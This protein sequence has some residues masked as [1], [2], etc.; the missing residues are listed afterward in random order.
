MRSVAAATG[1]AAA[2]LYRYV[3]TRD[4]VIEL[5]ADQVF[6]EYSYPQQLA[7]QPTADL[8][9]LARQG[10]AIYLRHPWLL[11]IPPAGRLPG[12]NAITFIE[13][14]LAALGGSGL[15]GQARLETIGL[16]SGAVRLIAQTEIDQRRA[17]QDATDWQDSLGGY[18][19]RI[20]TAGQHPHLAA[21][22]TESAV[23]AAD[24]GDAGPTDQLQDDPGAALI[25]RAL[26]RIVAGLLQPSG[27]MPTQ[28]AAR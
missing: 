17:G 21:A 11:D 3:T 1:T 4:E 27:D 16:F 5:M 23:R 10:L 24:A 15:T 28:S 13:H 9:V 19:L 6:G 7:G 12:P 8:L 26:T 22:L 14:A 25:D 2:S 20:A 18:L